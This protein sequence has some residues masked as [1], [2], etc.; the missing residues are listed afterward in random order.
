MRSVVALI[1]ASWL[2][3]ASYRMQM[4]FSMIGLVVS[5]F[6]L[7]LL[8]Q[9]LQPVMGGALSQEGDQ[10]FAFLISGLLVYAFMRAAVTA[11]PGEVGTAIANGTL[12]ALI[13]TPTRLPV[14]LTGLI[15]YQFI[16]TAIRSVITVSFAALVGVH[17]FWGRS[18]VGLAILLLLI[19]SYL[20]VGI[21]CAALIIAFRSAGP[22]A[23]GT[24]WASSMLGGVYYPTHVM[25]AYLTGLSTVLPMS[26]GLRALRKAMLEP[27]FSYGDITGD[28]G[29]LALMTA[30]LLPMAIYSF[31]LALRHARRAG[32]L[33]QY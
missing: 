4:V 20:S 31:V 2:D 24:L 23:T 10:Y 14:L 29:R 11:L 7:Y 27:A 8:A 32:S 9:A 33:S 17:V 16:W 26:Y 12:E 25:P 22:I 13:G 5:V 21:F 18:L 28:V 30:V 3:A 15:G 6:P 19:G 1:R